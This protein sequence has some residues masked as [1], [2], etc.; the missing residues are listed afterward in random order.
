MKRD[1]K[2]FTIVE[3]LIAVAILS[4]VVASVCGFILVGSR[5]YAAGNSDISVQQE[6]QLALNQ[7]SD[8]V[9]DTTRSV[10]YAGYDASGSPVY[11]LKDAEFAFTPEDKSLV[12][13]NGV[14]V[15]NPSGGPDII[16]DG[17]GNKNYHFYWDKSEETLFYAEVDATTGTAPIFGDPGYEWVTLASHVTDFSVDLSQVQEKRV[18][19]LALTF[20]DGVKEYVTSNNVTIRNK[21][22]VNDAEL[23]PLNRK[24]TI[25]VAARDSGVIIEPGETY[26]FS[27]PRV[28]G[29]NVTDRSVTWSVETSGSPTGGTKFSDKDNGVLKVA[30]DETGDENGI[31]TVKI[32]TNAV[33]D[34][35]LPA[36]C[37]VTVYIKRVTSV[38]L[39]ASTDGMEG[40]V[41]L[42]SPGNTYTITGSAGGTKVGEVCSVCGEDTSVDDWLVYDNMGYTCRPN[43]FGRPL[44][45]YLHNPSVDG[46]GSSKFDPNKYVKIIEQ[47]KDYA[48]FEVLPGADTSI[49]GDPTH[50][51]GFVIQAAAFLPE[52]P[53]AYGRDY[54]MVGAAIEFKIVKNKT[55]AKP[56]EPGLSYG[57][58]NEENVHNEMKESVLRKEVKP[59]TG[60][61]VP[62]S[63]FVTCVN[64]VDNSGEDPVKT[65]LHFT[66]GGGADFRIAPDLFDLNLEKSY[67][68]YIQALSPVSI[69]NL[70]YGDD[71]KVDDK[72]VIWNEYWTHSNHEPPF[73]YY[74]DR[75]VYGDMYYGSLNKPMALWDYNGQTYGKE[76]SKMILDPVNV[77]MRSQD[78]ALI[79]KIY[80]DRYENIW[81]YDRTLKRMTYSVYVEDKSGAWKPVYTFDDTE[82][83][84]KYRGSRSIG[85]GVATISLGEGRGHINPEHSFMIM[86][87]GD[88]LKARGKYHIVPGYCY[89][90]TFDRST[91]DYGIIGWNGF[92]DC[93][94]SPGNE[95]EKFV[96]P[97]KLR[98]YEFKDLSGERIDIVA[99]LTSEFTMDINKKDDWFQ[100]SVNFPLPKDMLK[101]PSLFPNPYDLE[102]K[103]T[104]GPLTVEALK[105]GET[106]GEYKTFSYAN[107]RYVSLPTERWEVEPI[108]ITFNTQTKKKYIHSYGTYICEKN[109]TKWT[110]GIR[111]SSTTEE[112]LAFNLTPFS[113]DNSNDYQAFFPLPGE[114]GFP[115][116]DIEGEQEIQ[117]YE[118]DYYDNNMQ[119][120]GKVSNLIVTGKKNADGG[121]AI[122]FMKK[123]PDNQHNANNHKINVTSYGTYT[124]EAGETKWR[125]TAGYSVSHE[126]DFVANLENLTIGDNSYK[127]YFPLPSESK[128][129]FK[130]SGERIPC[131][132]EHVAYLMTDT[133]ADGVGSLDMQYNYDIEY[134]YDSGAK[135]HKITFRFRHNSTVYDTFTCSQNGKIWTPAH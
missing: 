122:E 6:A 47:G 19:M 112:E 108:E 9:I 33:G 40:N 1:Q 22:G 56:I 8:V 76:Q 95:T 20:V 21:V 12:M 52:Y 88:K 83:V 120:K 129:P 78:D 101:N 28:T 34:D 132:A 25:S 64:V 118:L 68:F 75:Y 72:D 90:N 103:S 31:V 121:Y 114:S 134:Q 46:D 10:N 16:E 41:H 61:Y 115:F 125:R 44:Y 50:T 100:G 32:T 105:T 14:L 93:P 119:H 109:G 97:H 82:G 110:E 54:G 131:T 94:Y 39:S 123:A 80:P 35:G 98:Y 127:M 65:I 133:Y 58:D 117:G 26:H 91:A 84:M 13:Y 30:S 2:G 102:W 43:A 73:D 17:N 62:E 107:Y 104:M 37:P 27:T 126:T 92:K 55:G 5:S 79:G 23:E 128:F 42:V 36:T 113:A 3:L 7:M 111:P 71:H 51:Y 48:K 99:E 11:A 74:G 70:L 89:D 57:T 77:Y 135:M 106:K 53:N 63:S 130:N 18:V 4:I 87:Q 69:D 59:G 24:K 85:D 15:K 38:N 86:H 67:T 60:K 29:E 81:H 45:W 96:L 49:E 124:W 116:A 66:I